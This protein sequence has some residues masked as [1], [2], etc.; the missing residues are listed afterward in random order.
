LAAE[1]V[2]TVE[3]IYG[4]GVTTTREIDGVSVV[5]V[6]SFNPAIFQPG[7]LGPS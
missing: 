4:S 5:L 2:S 6:G 3:F 1:G 7:W